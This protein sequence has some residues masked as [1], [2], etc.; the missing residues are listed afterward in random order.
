MAA[1]GQAATGKATRL[2]HLARH[3]AHEYALEGL[4]PRLLLDLDPPHQVRAPLAEVRPESAERRS[5]RRAHLRLK[6]DPNRRAGGGAAVD[7]RVQPDRVEERLQVREADL[8]GWG[9]EAGGGVVG[10]CPSQETVAHILP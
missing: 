4:D 1:E 7:D 9:Q 6:L 5:V 3:F 8:H 10:P 2:V